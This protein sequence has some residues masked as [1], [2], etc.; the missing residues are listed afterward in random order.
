MIGHS[1][2]LLSR[3]VLARVPFTPE[4]RQAIAQALGYPAEWLFQGPQPPA[5]LVAHGLSELR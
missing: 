3:P 4:E 5:R 2:N 1:E